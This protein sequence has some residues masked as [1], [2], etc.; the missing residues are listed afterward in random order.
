MRFNFKPAGAVAAL[1]LAV[2]SAPSRADWALTTVVD[3]IKPAPDNGQV[4]PQ[5][6]PGFTWSRYPV[7]P[8]VASYVL[9]VKNAAGTVVATYSTKRNFYLPSTAFA[10]GTYTWRVRPVSNTDWSTSRTF[11]INQTSRT[12]IVPETATVHAAV[13]AHPRPRMLPRNF[14]PATQ[15]TADMKTARGAALA[16]LTSDVNSKLSVTPVTESMWPTAT[17]LSADAK[18]AQFYDIANKLGV[19]TIQLESSS[20]LYRL[21]GDARYKTEALARGDQL[22]ALDPNGATSYTNQ[23]QVTRQIAL[24]MAKA[25]DLLGSEVDAVRKA[26]WLA[27]IKART[28]PI[29]NDLSGNDGRMDQYPYDSHGAEAVGYMTLI[30]A[31]TIGDIPEASDWFDFGFRTYMHGIFVWSG[32][33]GGYANGTAYGQFTTDAAS[34]VWGPLSEATGVSVYDKPWAFGFANFFMHFTPPGAPGH[35]FGD[36]RE[37]PLDPNLLKGYVS[38]FKTPE[39]AWYYKNLVGEEPALSLLRAPYPL[40]AT[41]VTAVA[42]PNAALYPSIGWV[43]MHSDITDRARTSVYFK[44]SPY[45]TFNHSHADQNSLVIDSGGRRLLTEAGYQDYFM[46]TL[47]I[48]WYRTTKA[49]NAISFD[50]G[51]GQSVNDGLLNLTRTGKINAFSTTP[52]M[53][54][55]EGDATPA[56]AGLLT[57]AVRKVWYLR[58][59]DAVVVLDKLTSTTARNF[60]WNMHGYGPMV[61]EADG[62]IKITNADR[63][64]CI[65]SLSG[66]NKFKQRIPGTDVPLSKPGM[67]ETHGYF[68]ADASLKTEFLV[69]L[70]VGCKRPAVKLTTGTGS[71]SLTVGNQV[72]TLP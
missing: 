33:E 59:Q 14:V 57:S 52:A 30:A 38:R 8:R 55:V 69:V 16:K 70:D 9:E 42:P 10:A 22:A 47:G 19:M 41:T 25:L 50:G 53:D 71:R 1:M 63:M 40:P 13:L 31:L 39:A 56:Y 18:A 20:E 64:V 5:N 72:V 46:S 66:I 23:D 12:F 34:Q 11:V 27:I 2:V 65:R 43:A 62:T 26:R 4:Q 67:T 17:L 58:S 37:S 24:T 21:T 54:F 60:E 51:L 32:P 35:V 3:A 29:Y 44:A 6:P 45:G 48:S 7:Y 68:Q 15:W 49:H 61:Q 28:T 36:A